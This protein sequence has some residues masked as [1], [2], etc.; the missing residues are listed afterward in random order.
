MALIQCP[1]CGKENVSDSAEMCPLCGYGVK[2]HF[3]KLKQ[4]EEQR[5]KNEEE[6]R[7]RVLI[8]ERRKQLEESKKKE[9]KEKLFGSKWKIIL[10]ICLIIFVAAGMAFFFIRNK[11]IKDAQYSIEKI[12]EYSNEINYKLDN[13][14]FVYGS[15]Q[16]DALIEKLSTDVLM[17]EVFVNTT[18]RRYQKGGKISTEIDAYVMNNTSEKSWDDFRDYITKRYLGA[19]SSKENADKLVKN[20]SYSSN[21]EYIKALRKEKQEQQKQFEKTN[22]HVSEQDYY[23]SGNDIKIYG[24]VLNNTSQTVR[25]VKVK[26]SLLDANG[27]VI[28]TDST[29][30]CGDEGLAPGESTKFEC[31]LTYDPAVECFTAEVY[32]YDN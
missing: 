3:E 32:D 6:E 18:D 9:T 1:E 12:I 25:F 23:I 21:D 28:D 31:Y 2:A 5:I 24:A 17:L 10:L 14:K 13:A 27:A 16:S 30:A 15:G 26:I 4:E 22:V 7:E 11:E 20:A 29:Y 19:D 8:E